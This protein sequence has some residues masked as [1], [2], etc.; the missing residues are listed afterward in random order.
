MYKTD[1]QDARREAHIINRQFFDLPHDFLRLRIRKLGNI[2]AYA[3]QTEDDDHFTV[4]HTHYPSYKFF[5]NVL[6]HELIH[7][8]QYYHNLAGTHDK[9]FFTWRKPML[10]YGY[11]IL[12]E[13]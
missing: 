11:N 6:A 7:Q 2:W 13:Y 3:E 5:R 8:W 1:L 9:K 12:K 10:K 4:L